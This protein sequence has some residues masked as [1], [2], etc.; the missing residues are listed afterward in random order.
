MNQKQILFIL[1]I[2]VHCTNFC[3]K[4]GENYLN[5]VEKYKCL[6][7]ILNE[8]LEYDTTATILSE[9]AGRALGAVKAKTRHLSDLGFK[10]FEKLFC[11]GVVPILGYCSEIWGFK[12]FQSSDSIQE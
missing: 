12:N 10:R 2:R 6:G 9:A 1:E 7:V 4:L 8:Y 11:S 5:K 3:L